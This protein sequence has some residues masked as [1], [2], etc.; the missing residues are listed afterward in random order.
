MG[1]ARPMAMARLLVGTTMLLQFTMGKHEV[2]VAWERL[3]MMG[4]VLPHVG[5]VRC[6]S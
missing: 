4:R 5:L 1:V 6:T 2:A 3:E